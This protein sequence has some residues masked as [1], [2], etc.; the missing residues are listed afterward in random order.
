MNPT[1][2]KDALDRL[3]IGALHIERQ[4]ATGRL[5]KSRA[6][7]SGRWAF[8]PYRRQVRAGA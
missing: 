7:A 8:R 5:A 1:R 3:A 6:T 4:P 2:G